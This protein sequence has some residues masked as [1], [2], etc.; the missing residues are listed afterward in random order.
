M[1]QYLTKHRFFISKIMFYC[2][3]VLI[4]IVYLPV[5]T[6]AIDCMQCSQ[7]LKFNSSDTLEGKPPKCNTTKQDSDM[8]FATLIIQF[9]DQTASAYL[10]HLP[11]QSL[12]FSN[13]RRTTI[14]TMLIWFNKNIASQSVLSMGHDHIA[15][16][17]DTKKIYDQGNLDVNI[18]FTSIIVCFIF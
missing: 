6:L 5:P 12:T 4:F 14:N 15:V 7:E 9:E 18:Q 13:G 1:R 11:D 2:L 10:S 17:D 3:A 16:A 8:C